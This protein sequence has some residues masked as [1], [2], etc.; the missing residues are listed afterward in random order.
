MRAEDL[1]VIMTARGVD[2][3]H[4]A[5]LSGDPARRPRK[6]GGRR[7]RFGEER[8]EEGPGAQHGTATASTERPT[9]TL[10]EIGMASKG[11]PDVSFKAACFAFAGDH[12]EYWYLYGQLVSA[13]MTLRDREH[14]PWKLQTPN[15]GRF[16]LQELAELVLT[17]D[18]EPHY[19]RLVPQLYAWCLNIPE[20]LWDRSVSRRFQAVRYVW[21]TWLDEAIRIIG[22][23]LRD[24]EDAET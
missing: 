5:R 18:R 13:V 10:A 16:Y 15:G 2:L 6:L 12:S 23:R 21:M 7:N 20:P 3:E 19:F 14:W 1:L 22:P 17:E 9:W 11:V 8:L 4:T 24:R